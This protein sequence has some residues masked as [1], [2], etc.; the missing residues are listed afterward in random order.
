MIVCWKGYKQLGEADLLV[1]LP[2]FD[3]IAAFIYPLLAV[4]NIFIKT[5]SWK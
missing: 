1:F 3:I 2:L 5:K 4:S